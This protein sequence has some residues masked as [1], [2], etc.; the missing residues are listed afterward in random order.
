MIGSRTRLTAI[1]GSMALTMS[2]AAAP[3]VVAQ[4]D[5]VAP[6]QQV[7]TAVSE[8]RFG[9][10]T[11]PFCAELEAVALGGLGQLDDIGDMGLG[12]D[13]SS[14]LSAV[15]IDTSSLDLFVV[16]EGAESATVGLSGTVQVG[17]DEDRLAELMVGVLSTEDEPVDVETVKG[18]LPLLLPDIESMS[19]SV[20]LDESIEVVREAGVWQVCDDMTAIVDALGQAFE[21]PGPDGGS[22]NEESM[23]AEPTEEPTEEDASE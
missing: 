11:E 10:A 4:E 14:L 8:G 6:V 3:A 20:E 17:I 15:A 18:V 23:A 22:A 21:L 16:E 12:F 5:P 9:D 7:L 2:L 19:A 13:L 1:A